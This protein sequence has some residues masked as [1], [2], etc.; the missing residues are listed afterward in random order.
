MRKF[1]VVAMVAASLSGCSWFGSGPK[2]HALQAA[3]IGG[4]AG[5]IVGGVATGNSNGVAI[6]AGIGA[7]A[8]AAISAALER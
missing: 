2:N 1:A 6:G 5:A 8:G 3:V 4:I 7:A